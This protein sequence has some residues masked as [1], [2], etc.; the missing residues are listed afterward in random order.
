MSWSV[1]KG[2]LALLG[3]GAAAAA[4]YATRIEPGWLKVRYVPLRLPDLPH[5]FHDYRIIHISDLHMGGWL[6]RAR[7]DDAV[8]LINLL[9]PDAVAITGDFVDYDTAQVAGDLVGALGQ[10]RPRDVTVA[11]LGNHDYRWNVHTMRQVLRQSG[12]IDLS[13]SLHTIEREGAALHLAGVDT[14]TMRRDNLDAVLDALPTDGP[15][16]L[17]AHEPDFADIS[18][19]TGRFALQLSGHSHGGQVRLPFFGPP[20]LPTHGM[21]YPAGRYSI[22]GMQLYT[23][24]GLGMV[25]PHL[26]FNTRPEVTVLILESAR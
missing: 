3:I 25:R 10:L 21:R 22:N 4:F 23:N 17:L 15:A 7:L 11:V 2:L 24:R 18:A 13:N 9:R 26:R 14:V 5:A 19:A 6:N 1:R 16:L 12:I 20:M 8:A